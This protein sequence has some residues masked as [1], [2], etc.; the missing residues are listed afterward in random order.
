[1]YNDLI[2][3]MSTPFE[4]DTL[5]YF[6]HLASYFSFLTKQTNESTPC[7]EFYLFNMSHFL[8]ILENMVSVFSVIRYTIIIKV[9][10][11]TIIV[12]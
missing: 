6:T 4:L 9:S 2:V 3:T 11:D 12:Q 8:N 10:K 1:M 7:S 5:S